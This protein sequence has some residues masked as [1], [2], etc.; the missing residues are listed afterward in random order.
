LAPTLAEELAARIRKEGKITFRDWMDAALYHPTLGYYNRADLKRWG[1]EGDYR[2]SP[3][4]SDLFAA[5]LARYFVSLF[6]RMRA[7]PPFQIVEFGAGNGMFAAGVLNTLKTDHPQIFDSTNYVILESS[8]DSQTRAAVELEAVIDHVMFVGPTDLDTIHSGIVFSNELL[9]AFPV[10]RIRKVDGQLKELY[11][12]LDSS[13][14]FIWLLDELSSDAVQE[15]CVQFLPELAADQTVEVNLGIADWFR[16][17]DE[18]LVNG[19]VVTIDYG[20][21]AEDLYHQPA[22]HN[23]TLRAFSRH[24]FVDDLLSE[25]GAYDITST[26]NWSCVMGQ[27]KQYGFEVEEFEQ[28]DKFLLKAGVLQELETWIASARSDSERVQLTTAAREMVLPGGMASSFQVLVQR[29]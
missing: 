28:L 10:H 27:G 6:A 8:N 29:R 4:R 2:T 21:D 26:V 9:D 17:V 14:Q 3:E 13:E 20:A 5:T 19:Y 11:V 23:G 18:K 1:R 7:Q 16:L 15:F 24:A 22:R 12:G 25:P